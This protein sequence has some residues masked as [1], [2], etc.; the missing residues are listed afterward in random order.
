ME[1]G[2][3]I[4]DTFTKLHYHIVFSTM[5][6]RQIIEDEWRARLHDYIGGTLRGIGGHSLIVGGVRDHVHI[7]AGLRPSHRLSDVMREIKHES[8]RWIHENFGGGF[9][10]QKGYGAF[11]VSP[12]ACDRIRAYIAD[13]PKHHGIPREG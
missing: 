12:L 13:Q 3:L 2:Q 6:R 4:Q 7:L 9:A 10:W 11:T 1:S 5:G 8:S